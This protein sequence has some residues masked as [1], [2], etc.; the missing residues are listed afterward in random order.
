[1]HQLSIPFSLK[2]FD[3]ELT[4]AAPLDTPEAEKAA[5]E[6]DDAQILINPGRE[7]DEKKGKNGFLVSMS[8]GCIP[9][10]L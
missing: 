5:G 6:A 1:M 8:A 9:I 3:T 4:M 10:R 7:D 2:V